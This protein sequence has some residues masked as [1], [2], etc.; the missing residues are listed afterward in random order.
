MTVTTYPLEEAAEHFG[1]S[2]EWLA[3]QLRS[4]RFSGYKVGRKWRMSDADIAEALEK[5]R[6]EVRPETPAG[7]VEA[8][9]R[10]TSATATTR[11]RFAS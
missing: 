9:S 7:E 6:R 11:R 2:P 10:L 3:V 1:N 4:G 8:G 5:C